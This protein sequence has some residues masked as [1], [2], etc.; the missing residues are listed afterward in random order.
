[1]E[2][3]ADDRC[4]AILLYSDAQRQK[5]EKVVHRMVKRAIE[6][7]GTV[8]VRHSRILMRAVRRE[9]ARLT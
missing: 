4:I 1:M 2:Q 9:M 3:G 6:M 8:T 7:E 5:A